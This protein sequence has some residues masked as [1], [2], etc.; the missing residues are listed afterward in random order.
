MHDLTTVWVEGVDALLDAY[1]DVQLAGRHRLPRD[2]PETTKA[3]SA[4]RR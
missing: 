1:P 2:W 3:R 4:R